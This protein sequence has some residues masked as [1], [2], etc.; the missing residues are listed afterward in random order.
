MKEPGHLLTQEELKAEIETF[1]KP[2]DMEAL[3]VRGLVEK[4]GAWY[5]VPNMHKLPNEVTA[6]ISTMKTAKD[7]KPLVKFS[8]LR[9]IERTAAK[10]E[11]YGYLSAGQAHAAKAKPSAITVVTG[12]QK[13][14]A[15]HKWYFI[16]WSDEARRRVKHKSEPLYDKEDD[17]HAAAHDW[18]RRAGAPSNFNWGT[19]NRRLARR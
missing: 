11:K 12:A 17:A 16:L 10:A 7:G 18:Q 5:Y 13:D 15:T 9:S 4:R 8:S 2:F 19:R 3:M 6:K 14:P 1:V